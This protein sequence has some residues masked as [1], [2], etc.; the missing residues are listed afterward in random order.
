MK[1]SELI[2]ELQKW[3]ADL[4]I[5]IDVDEPY[6]GDRIVRGLAGV[7]WQQGFYAIALDAQSY[8]VTKLDRKQFIE[9]D[10]EITPK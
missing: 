9:C 2:T 1:V 5:H 7:R 4:E 8:E 6:E 10:F 3:P